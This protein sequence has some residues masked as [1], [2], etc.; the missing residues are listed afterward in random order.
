M[1]G[2]SD[3]SW[4]ETACGESALDWGCVGVMA[5]CDGSLAEFAGVPYV[6]GTHIARALL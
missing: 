6:E 4:R 3:F 5:G 1:D 2:A